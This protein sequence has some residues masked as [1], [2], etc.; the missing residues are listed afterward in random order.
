[1]KFTLSWL[2]RH[3]DTNASLE[4]ICDKLTAIG[5]E[6]E[7][8]ED[9][10]KKYEAFKVAYVESAVQHPNAD[11][12]RVCMVKTDKGV[13]QVVCGAPNAR[14]GMKA[15]FAPEGSVI[16]ASG[17]VLKKGKIRD[18]ESNGMLVSEEE[19][20]LPETIDGIIEVDAKWDIGTPMAEI[21]G[22][23]DAVIE[24]NLTP[25]RADCAGVLGIARDLAA[26]GLGKLKA[27]DAKPVKGT[28]KSPVSVKIEDTDGCYLFLGRHFKGVKN[29]PSPAWLQN[30]LKSIGLRPISALVDITNFL[31][32]GYCRPMH[33]Y[34]AKK[35]KGNI[36]VRP[37]KKGVKLE[38]LNDKTYDMIDGA[39]GIYDES[40][41]HGGLIGLGGI[42]GGSS[43][44]CDEATSDVFLEAAVFNPARLSRAGRDLDVQS[45]ARYR[46]ERGVDP[47]F[48]Y[49]GIEIATALILEICGGE[50]SEVVKAGET[51]KWQ[52]SID[53]DF[54]F[55]KKRTGVDVPEKRQKEIFMALGFTVSGNK[56]QPPSWRGDV[57]GK[58]DITEEIIRI[59]GF[60]NI[61]ALSVH[62]EG[63]VP[64]G[65][66]TSTL[67]RARKARTAMAARGLQECVTWS[68][69]PGKTAAHFND[70]KPLDALTLKNP[71]SADL[72]VMRPSALANLIAAAARNNDLGYPDAALCEVGPVFK[73]P[74]P[75]GQAIVASGIRS[76]SMNAR[77][78]ADT[79]AAREI[80]AFDAKADALAVLESCGAPN[81][82]VSRDVPSYYHPGRAGALKLG[83]NVLAWFGEI[84]PA[85]LDAMG[86]DMPVSGFE[87]FLQNIPE[88][89]KKG[90]EKP[91]LKLEPLQPVRRDFAFLVD[92]KIEAETLIRAAKSADKNLIDDAYV[93][94][95]YTGK[96]VDPGK[97]SVA[98]TVTIQPR[99]KTLTDPEIEALAKK[100]VEA[101]T[102][103]TGGSLRG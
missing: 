33:V 95:I 15:V 53:Y 98:L 61:P 77:N 11:R 68:F 36:A 54:A 100:I 10:A 81:V 47:E 91:L 37:T 43:T 103:K 85:V 44:G 12:L 30:L 49:T 83:N 90:T 16:P 88:A 7:N 84:H 59:H 92:M 75:D 21:F 76:G 86:V 3:L 19:M 14:S 79:N 6:V 50:A 97:K 31:T 8:V 51:P 66:E 24:I 89:K 80:D 22:L 99:E 18:V 38:A 27:V 82:Q 64:H 62:S 39:V 5:L 56:I 57:E 25:N 46:L 55:T 60:E 40:T 20:A 28:F 1:M 101:V 72:D 73:S 42:V 71:I 67:S 35:L 94:D 17:M 48:T 29:G 96:G 41:E 58:A 70:N 78:W 23:N 93:F 65:A 34:D 45:D 69:M 26:A 2:K 32:L 9:P 74:R 87:V 13:L 102:G 63:A 4:E 52:R